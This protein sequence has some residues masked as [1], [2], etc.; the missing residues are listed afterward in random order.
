M[1]KKESQNKLWSSTL[2]KYLPVLAAFFVYVN[3][4]THDFTLDD[5]IVIYDNDFTKQGIKGIPALLKYDT[6]RGFFKVEG[7]DNL[8]SGGRYRPLTPIMFALE[9]SISTKPWFHHLMNVLWYAALVW[10]ILLFLNIILPARLQPLAWM[11][12]M[13]FALHPIHTEVIA[14]IKGRDEIVSM[15]LGLL[16]TYLLVKQKKHATLWSVLLIFLALLAKE[17]A[18]TFIPIA[19]IT[20]YFFRKTS[21]LNT[22]KK[23]W[24]LILGAVIYILLRTS[25]LGFSS[26][27]PTMEMMNNPF[28]KLSNGQYEFFS[29][30]E[31]VSSIIYALGLYLKLLFF[32]HPLTHDYYPRQLNI[33]SFSDWRVLLSIV[34]Y[35]SL[36]YIMLKGWQKRKIYS[37][38]IAFFLLSLILISNIIFPIGTHMGERFVFLASLG[39]S[40]L[41]AYIIL[42]L[43][44][45]GFVRQV[46]LISILVLFAIK[47]ITRNVV[48]KDDYTLFTTDVKTSSNSAKCLNAAA[49]S[50]I[51]KCLNQNNENCNSNEIDLGISYAQEAIRIHPNYK[52]AHLILG[53]GYFIQDKYDDAITSYKNALRI[54]PNMADAKKNLVIVLAKAARYFGEKKNDFNKSIKL[55]NE[56]KTID[57]DNNEVIRLLGVAHGVKGDLEKALQYFSDFYRRNPDNEDG[58]K[59]L[60]MTYRNM[61]DLE[62]AEALERKL[63]K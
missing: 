24:P 43:F 19:M 7:K 62:K 11:T 35:I 6:F 27:E 21:F 55:L 4:I 60:I 42:S 40:L 29:L 48:W 61:G 44:K 8:V 52:N 49:G 5:A 15:A 22:I 20:F 32:P 26:F 12:T 38:A 33:L 56:A 30:P 50:I 17:M 34:A 3:T 47:T 51:T 63:K 39:F 53:N 18:I 16:A 2:W 23:S 25:V 45:N 37:Y 36:I 59:N 14:N 41:M 13:I 1:A 31:K 28:V 54:D 57:P 9:R 58:I 46:I 10:I